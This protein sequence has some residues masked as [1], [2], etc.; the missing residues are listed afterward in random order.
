M[1]EFD[2]GDFTPGSII[3]TRKG[4]TGDVIGNFEKAG[5]SRRTIRTC[6]TPEYSMLFLTFTRAYGDGNLLLK[7]IFDGNFI[8]Y[9]VHKEQLYDT[10]AKVNL[11]SIKDLDPIDHWL[12]NRINVHGKVFFTKGFSRRLTAWCG[13]YT[14]HKFP[15]GGYT[16][17]ER[18]DFASR[19]PVVGIAIRRK[20]GSRSLAFEFLHE[21]KVYWKEFKAS[22]L[23]KHKNDLFESYFTR[24]YRDNTSTKFGRVSYF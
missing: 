11:P 3:M 10:F 15:F 24:L 13:R 18:K 4:I 9:Y 5:G 23:V 19:E 20:A 8:D 16:K 6:D 21:N 7:C 2:F 17:Y 22:A 14:D 12:T 1:A